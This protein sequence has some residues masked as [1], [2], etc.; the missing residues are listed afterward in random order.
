MER[1]CITLPR[2]IAWPARQSEW[3]R[4]VRAIRAGRSMH[5]GRLAALD[6]SIK[7]CLCEFAM[8]F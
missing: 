3:A 8:A 1:M 5:Q 6:H 2:A 7:E 4:C